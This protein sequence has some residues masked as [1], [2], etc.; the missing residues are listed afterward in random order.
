MPAE[1]VLAAI[2]TADLTIKYGRSLIELY[3]SYKN[4][5]A[6][7]GE[8]IL[9]METNW[10][11]TEKQLDFLKRIW[12]KLDEDHQAIQLRILRLLIIN[13]ES[14]IEEVEKL[15]HTKKKGYAVGS[16]AKAEPEYR[17]LRYAFVKKGLDATIASLE[18]W[19]RAFDPTWFLI[20][21]MS[22]ALVDVELA[23]V[24]RSTPSVNTPASPNAS[25]T[26]AKTIR[27]SLRPEDAGT[28]SSIFLPAEG[29][30]S[31]TRTPI[32]YS[33][34]CLLQRGPKNT[35][36]I[37][38]SVQSLP[39]ADPAVQNT[40]VRDLARKLANT[41]PLKFGLL[42]C[43]GVVKVLDANR[44]ISSYDFVFHIPPS[45]RSPPLSL[46]KI[47][48]DATPDISLSRRF[49][50]AQ[51]LAQS[52]SY[53]HTYGFVHK[54]IRPETIL[55]FPNQN[56]K[57]ACLFLLG[58]EKFRPA[59]PGRTLR[60]GDDLWQKEL[61]RHPRRQGLRPEDEYVMQHDIYSL[62]VC[63]LEIGLWQSLVVHHPG[64]TAINTLRE[65]S[66]ED[67]P[68]ASP[69][70]PTLKT[71][72][73]DKVK[74]A[75]LIKDCLVVLAKRELPSRMGDK[76]TDIVTSCLTCLDETNADFSD[77]SEFMDEDGI[78]IGVRYIEK[79]LLQLNDISV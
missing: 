63:L 44:K 8:R 48:I 27:D 51:Q 9:L 13:L 19:Q 29:I 10:L 5:T 26:S 41:D 11:R 49:H 33:T 7:I 55:I 20:L 70:L 54:G 42:Q 46:R 15:G 4:A 23:K 47:L 40:D 77:E 74:N 76:Y 73:N 14:A 2:G 71:H 6:E 79:I 38:D 32:Q 50:I 34:A 30:S 52:L 62:G 36:Y 75:S 53:V 65:S 31:S 37:L 66:T 64:S 17:R 3:S 78:T 22:D 12:D 28:R 39:E 61:Y 56:D 45:L 16:D 60:A 21:R 35:I 24:T 18:K 43:R 25:I 58:F 67:Q 69:L 68:I 1:L 57:L 72:N 59:Q